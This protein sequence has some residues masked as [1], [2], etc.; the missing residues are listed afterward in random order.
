M[1]PRW[2]AFAAIAASVLWSCLGLIDYG[3]V[4]A[5]SWGRSVSE[6]GTLASDERRSFL[7]RA[8]RTRMRSRLAGEER[9]A[10]PPRSAAAE[11]WQWCFERAADLSP[12][13]RVHLNVPSV[14]LYYF[15]SFFFHPARLEADPT[16]SPITGA[17]SLRTS[18]RRVKPGDFGLLAAEGYSHA[19]IARR[20]GFAL[21]ELRPREKGRGP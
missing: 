6:R 16:G 5:A 20:S 13:A 11:A 17:H 14:E 10:T 15:C 3:R 12:E 1:M 19:I 9:S 18:Q 2:I 8:G 21:V 7:T 4:L